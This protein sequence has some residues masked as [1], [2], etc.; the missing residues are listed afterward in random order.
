MT[1]N[2]PEELMNLSRHFMGSRILLTGVELNIFDLLNKTSLA[3]QEISDKLH[4]DL[5]ATTIL[6]DAL[7]AMGLLVKID[8]AY[9]CSPPLSPYLSYDSPRSILPMILHA[10]HLWDRWTHLTDIV[11]GEAK[12]GADGDAFF[13]GDELKA[14]I[15]AMHAVSGPRA[16]DVIKGITHDQSKALLDLGGASGTYTIAFLKSS[17]AMKA[18]LFDLPEVIELAR[19]RLEKEGM[20][21]RIT[22]AGGNYLRDEIPP[23][24]DLAFLSAVIHS[25]SPVQNQDLYKKVFL[26]LI[27]GGRI[28]IR[29]QVMEADRTHPESGAIFAV[30]MLV[31]TEGGRTYTFDEIKEG[32]SSAG[33]NGIRLLD[34]SDSRNAIVEAYSLK[35]DGTRTV[36]KHYCTRTGFQIPSWR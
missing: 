30:N 35:P 36:N 32:L 20:L 29:D 19:E 4:T 27:P 1:C 7:A 34:N 3:A 11:K 18:T 25:N 28:I 5:R 33:F 14:F 12:S 24:H 13:S 8:E 26:S 17:P 21:D 2:T 16:G 6:L 22:L 9:Q 15:G 10:S 31:A 23:G